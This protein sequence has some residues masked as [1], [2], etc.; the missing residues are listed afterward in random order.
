MVFVKG[1]ICVSDSKSTVYYSKKG[2]VRMV[3]TCS[4]RLF[5]RSK[6]LNLWYIQFILV[7]KKIQ[8]ISY[9][10]HLIM[11]LC[12][13][14][15][16][17]NV[18][19]RVD[20]EIGYYFLKIIKTILLVFLIVYSLISFQTKKQKMMFFVLI[21]IIISDGNLNNCTL[22]KVHSNEIQWFW[23]SITI[24][25]FDYKTTTWM[26]G[27]LTKKHRYTFPSISR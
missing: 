10:N 8:C 15:R 17:W 5:Q 9:F 11:L 22:Y 25:H 2:R 18:F 23:R 14:Y 3:F 7:P 1:M 13:S 21:F 12:M 27:K 6:W 4:Y 24:P 16:Q 19:L 26:T 20:S